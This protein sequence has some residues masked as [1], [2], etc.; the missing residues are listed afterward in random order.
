MNL[1]KFLTKKSAQIMQLAQVA[2]SRG[3]HVFEHS[4]DVRI[5][6]LYRV[7]GIDNKSSFYSRPGGQ[8]SHLAWWSSIGLPEILS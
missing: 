1:K 2:V 5:Q 8:W 3:A 7:R 4:I 6:K